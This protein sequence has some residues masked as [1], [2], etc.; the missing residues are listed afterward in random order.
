MHL[1]RHAALVAVRPG[2]RSSRMAIKSPRLRTAPSRAEAGE[3]GRDRSCGSASCWLRLCGCNLA[4]MRPDARRR[5]VCDRARRVCGLGR[6]LPIVDHRIERVLLPFSVTDP[7]LPGW[8]SMR[9]LGKFYFY[10]P[11][12]PVWVPFLGLRLCVQMGPD[13]CTMVPFRAAHLNVFDGVR[14]KSAARS[15]VPK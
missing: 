14:P 12:F 1:D 10:P 2:A 7:V 11:A 9:R 15:I 3:D 13:I 4:T 6:D 5:S 8:G